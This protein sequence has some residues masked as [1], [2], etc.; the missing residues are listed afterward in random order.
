MKSYHYCSLLFCK[1]YSITFTIKWSYSSQWWKLFLIN[2][3]GE[4]WSDYF[5][6]KWIKLLNC[7]RAENLFSPGPLIGRCLLGK[8]HWFTVN[9]IICWTADFFSFTLQTSFPRWCIYV[10][11]DFTHQTDLATRK[12]EY[13]IYMY[14]LCIPW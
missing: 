10:I 6:Q 1:L 8:V 11:T 9:R 5:H 13:I 2:I 7:R 4:L 3:S 14:I 12:Y